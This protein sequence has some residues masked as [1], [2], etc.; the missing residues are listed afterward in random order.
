MNWIEKIF[1]GTRALLAFIV[2][3]SACAVF[4]A[5]KDAASLKELGLVAVTFYFTDKITRRV[6]GN[7]PQ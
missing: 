6:N 1:G 7:P 3:G 4:I 5:M 2:V